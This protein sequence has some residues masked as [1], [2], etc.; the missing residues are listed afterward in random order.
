MV[1][2]RC[3]FIIF[4]GE[5]VDIKLQWVVVVVVVDTLHDVVDSIYD[6]LDLYGD[7]NSYFVVY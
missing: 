7:V 6:Q 2:N 3:F 4:K 1:I 5:F